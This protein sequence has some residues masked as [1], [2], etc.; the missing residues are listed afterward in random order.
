MALARKAGTAPG[1]F[2]ME[3]KMGSELRRLAGRLLRDEEGDGV[4]AGWLADSAGAAAEAVESGMASEE[5][6]VRAGLG[7]WWGSETG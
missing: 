5:E 1:I 7:S 4:A 6:E 2:L 3:P